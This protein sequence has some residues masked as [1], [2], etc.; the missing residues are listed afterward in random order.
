M[1]EFATAISS[2]KYDQ[3]SRKKQGQPYHID[4]VTCHISFVELIFLDAWQAP[5]GLLEADKL[6]MFL[7]PHVHTRSVIEEPAIELIISIFKKLC[8]LSH[9]NM[10]TF[11]IPSCIGEQSHDLETIY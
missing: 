5:S 4:H 2:N 10:I 6:K 7:L 8:V 1:H 3:V 11:N 9:S